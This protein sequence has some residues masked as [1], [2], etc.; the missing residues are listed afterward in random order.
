MPA[1]SGGWNYPGGRSAILTPPTGAPYPFTVGRRTIRDVRH[2]H[3]YVYSQLPPELR[4]VFRDNSAV[5]GLVAANLCEFVTAL[6]TVPAVIADHARNGSL[7]HWLGG[8]Y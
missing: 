2:W 7:S 4:F 6:H 5:T 1:S 3:K 8:V